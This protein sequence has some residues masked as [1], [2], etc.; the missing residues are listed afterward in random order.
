MR[1]NDLLHLIATPAPRLDRGDSLGR[2]MGDLR[3]PVSRQP[4]CR[5][6]VRFPIPQTNF[7]PYIPLSAPAPPVQV[8]RPRTAPERPPKHH[9]E[10]GKKPVRAS[11][12]ETGMPRAGRNPHKTGVRANPDLNT[13]PQ[14]VANNPG[15]IDYF[16]MTSKVVVVI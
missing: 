5:I 11:E 16:R 8:C 2:R 10:G 13:A 1:F 4:R 9:L 14:Q 15:A 6:P 12:S 7:S 3:R